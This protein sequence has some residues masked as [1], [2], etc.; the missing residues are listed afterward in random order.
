[1]ACLEWVQGEWA[2]SADTVEDK[3]THRRVNEKGGKLPEPGEVE[4]GER[5]HAFAAAS[6]KPA[7]RVAS[8]LSCYLERFRP[9]VSCD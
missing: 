4:E 2:V 6:L 7:G 3:F 1:L 5:I 9:S 8:E